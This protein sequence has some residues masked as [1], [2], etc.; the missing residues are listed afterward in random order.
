MNKFRRCFVLAE[1]ILF[2]IFLFL[3]LKHLDSSAFKYLG[4]LLCFIYALFQ[5]NTEGSI[6]FLFTLLADWFLLIRNSDY[7]YGVLS[8][9]VVQLIYAYILFQKGSRV[10][11]VFRS[12]LAAVLLFALHIAGQFTLLNAVTLFYF[13]LLL[14]NL[15]SSFTNK[16]LRTMSGG[17]LL[18]VCCDIC[19]GL[20]NLFDHGPI[21][22]AASLLMWVFYLPSQVLLAIGQDKHQD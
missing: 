2:L 21:Y 14:G 15:F 1:T 11:F 17:F 5:K 9:I 3:D 22:N 6:A 7:L 4:I 10:L 16:K 8:F 13:S 18:F 19:V 20:F 12:V